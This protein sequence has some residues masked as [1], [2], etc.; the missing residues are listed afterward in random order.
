M[1]CAFVCRPDLCNSL[2]DPPAPHRRSPGS[3]PPAPGGQPAQRE[4]EE[5][6]EEEEVC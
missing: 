4:A 2:R 6:V 5:V 3:P 1:N